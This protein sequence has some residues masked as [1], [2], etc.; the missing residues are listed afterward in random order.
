MAINKDEVYFT[1]ADIRYIES[2]ENSDEDKRRLLDSILS[3]QA[4]FLTPDTSPK[5]YTLKS[6]DDLLEKPCATCK[7]VRKYIK[8]TI[9][10]LYPF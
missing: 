5:M 9:R 10:S 4:V 3:P 1:D 2:M 6:V 7:K 8:K